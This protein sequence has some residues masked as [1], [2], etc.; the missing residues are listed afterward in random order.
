MAHLSQFM[1][2]GHCKKKYSKTTSGQPLVKGS[3]VKQRGLN[4]RG[5]S[6]IWTTKSNIFIKYFKHSWAQKETP[7][8]ILVA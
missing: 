3:L 8:F 5:T 6:A 4:K 2:N 7:V 1:T